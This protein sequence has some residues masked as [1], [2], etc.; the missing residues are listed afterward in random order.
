MTTLYTKHCRPTRPVCINRKGLGYFIWNF[1]CMVFNVWN[2]YN[3]NTTHV[4]KPK[5]YSTITGASITVNYVCTA[6]KW[7]RLLMTLDNWVDLQWGEAWGNSRLSVVYSARHNVWCQYRENG[8]RAVVPSSYSTMV[9]GYLLLEVFSH[10]R[11]HLRTA[12]Y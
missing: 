2:E 8:E 1:I 9:K 6:Q 11:Q 10:F 7:V 12:Q 4:T 3:S 5:W